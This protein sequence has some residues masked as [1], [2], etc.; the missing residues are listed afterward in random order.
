MFRLLPLTIA[1]LIALCG[2]D[3]SVEADGAPPPGTMQVR[4]V[5][6]LAPPWTRRPNLLP[7]GSFLDWYAGSPVLRGFDFPGD[8]QVS[9]VDRQSIR[10]GL[11]GQAARQTWYR[12]D[13]DLPPQGLFRSTM[14]GLKPDT[15]YQFEV[16]ALPLDEIAAQA[17]IGVWGLGQG[18]A[19]EIARP[20]LRLD[21]VV[22][23]RITRSAQFSTRQDPL[24]L[25]GAYLDREPNGNA[26]VL[27]VEWRL[28][29]CVREVVVP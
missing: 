9:V 3:P 18:G 7:N 24:L 4:A 27:W 1:G 22:G 14:R 11:G 20:L 29:E 2:C 16:T 28:T 12:P 21:G 15:V 5:H 13:A 10:A 25:V 23:A 19:S 26:S 6:P 17:C 8:P